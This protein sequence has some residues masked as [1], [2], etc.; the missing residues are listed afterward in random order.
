MDKIN[1]FKDMT[2]NWLFIM[3]MVCT[4]GFQII[5]VEFLGTFASTVPLNWKFWLISILIGAVSLPVGGVIKFI[6]VPTRQPDDGPHDDYEILP[7][8]PEMA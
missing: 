2:N 8:G 1:V 4:V 7:S 3:V 5:I 6:P